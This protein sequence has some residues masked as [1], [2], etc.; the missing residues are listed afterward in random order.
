[1]QFSNSVT[2]HRGPSEVFAFLA[3]PANIPKWN[4]AISATRELT[5]GPFGVGTR[6]QQTRS[7][8][9]PAVEELEVTE[10]VPERRM[11]LRG[12]VGPL[13]GT[14]VYLVEQV[15]EGTRLTNAADLTGRGP[16]QLLAPFATGRVR[17][18]VAANLEKL[19]ALLESSA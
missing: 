1:M 7:F 18:A 6:L 4:Y 17:E 13:T 19:R 8:P 10:F 9:R 16:L 12:D 11:V 15:P 14:L 3:D 2:I 5:P